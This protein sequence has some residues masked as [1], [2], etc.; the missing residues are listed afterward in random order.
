MKKENVIKVVVVVVVI[1]LMFSPII[2]EKTI[3][4]KIKSM[5][6]DDLESKIT[7]TQGYGYTMIYVASK[8]DDEVKQNRKDIYAFNKTLTDAN[9]QDTLTS[10]FIDYD[11]LSSSEKD[12]IFGTSEEKS[13][14]V[15][16]VNG[17]YLTT[18]YG[19]KTID[20]LEPY[21]TAYSSNTMSPNLTNYKVLEDASS[22][23]KLVKSK[24]T[25]TMAVFGRDTCFYCNQFKIVYNQVAGEYGVD[26]YY[27]DSDS[28]D[29]DEYTA[30][31]DMGLKI[32]ASCSSTGEEVD[33]QPGF[34]TPL[35]LFTKNGKV[36]DCINGYVGK[37]ELLTK[38][39]TVGIL[40]I[41]EE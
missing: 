19:E 9:G 12:E 40:E 17:E 13:A 33:L 39:Q 37:S 30:I 28:Y 4:S 8:D 14:F 23:E 18:L 29:E 31:M 15:F 7:A 32:P 35:T 1:L 36:I 11:K 26:I 6:Y 3:G 41:T 34:G 22:Y 10:Y 21:I 5:K 16:Y 25:V 2:Y 20:D 38:L 27:F 24:K